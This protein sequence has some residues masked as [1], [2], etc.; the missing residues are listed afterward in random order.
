MRSV[1]R[2]PSTTVAPAAARVRAVASPKPLL[3]PVMTTT[4]PLMFSISQ[5]L[6]VQLAFYFSKT[7]RATRTADSARGQPA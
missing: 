4:F 6:T 2:A 7:S 5:L 3:A 1:R